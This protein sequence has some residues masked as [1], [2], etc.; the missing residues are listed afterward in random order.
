MNVNQ[1]KKLHS[2]QYDNIEANT[3]ARQAIEILAYADDICVMLEKPTLYAFVKEKLDLYSS[4][5]N[6]KFNQ[7]DKTE[8]FS[9]NGK[10]DETW[11]EFLE[12]DHVGAY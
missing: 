12:A 10:E 8:A 6:A 9:F 4:I 11:K 2:Q 1:K 3:G 7:Q 5:S